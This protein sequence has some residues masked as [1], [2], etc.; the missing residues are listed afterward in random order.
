VRRRVSITAAATLLVIALA[1]CSEQAET[2]AGGHPNL[3]IVRDFAA[4]VAVV[5]LDP[6]FGFSLQRGAPGVP[7]T[8]RAASV[9]RAAAFTLADTV[10]EQLRA[11]GYD[12]VRSD[13]AGP[14]PGGRA[15]VVSGAFR[16]IDE[17]YRRRVGAEGS[18]VAV[19][20]E[21][22]YLTSGERPQRLMAFQLDSQQVRGEGLVGASVR[23][24]PVNAA[25]ARVGAAI[26]RSVGELARRSNWPGAPR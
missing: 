19:D 22:T 6:S 18:S 23:R 16:S 1:A 10:A 8:Q 5:S 17:G 2:A 11:L 7:P 25:A 4:P 26:A 14:E 9:G 13:E 12:A 15:L 24:E 21:V 3:I 20:T